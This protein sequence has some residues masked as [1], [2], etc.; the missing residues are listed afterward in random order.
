MEAAQL[1]SRTSL[2]QHVDRI[3]ALKFK[4][5]MFSSDVLI[6]IEFSVMLS[7]FHDPWMAT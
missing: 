6:V 7:H 1:V 5:V 2:V 3:A 4:V